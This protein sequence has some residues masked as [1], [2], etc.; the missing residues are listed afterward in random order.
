M[1]F[2][3]DQIRKKKKILTNWHDTGE[4]RLGV[5]ILCGISAGCNA[6]DPHFRGVPATR[7]TVDGSVFDVRV[8]ANLAEAVRIN[9]E[10]APRFGPILTRAGFAMATVS[11]CRVKGVL[12][13]QALATGLL[14]CQKHPQNRKLPPTKASYSCQEVQQWLDAAK[15][16]DY[17]A[18]FTCNNS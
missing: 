8:G 14:V 10:Y 4:M 12:G 3:P 17:P 9:S 7:I 15:G 16:P 11:G 13:D 18:R 1:I 6:P 2:D 5:L